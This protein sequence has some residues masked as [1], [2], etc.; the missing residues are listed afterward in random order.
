MQVERAP[1]WQPQHAG[2]SRV[3]LVP[4]V[5]FDEFNTLLK[6]LKEEYYETVDGCVQGA[7][8]NN[9]LMTPRSISHCG[10]LGVWRELTQKGRDSFLKLTKG[11]GYEWCVAINAFLMTAMDSSARTFFFF[12][13]H[14]MMGDV[15]LEEYQE[16]LVTVL[17]REV[18][19]FLS[20]WDLQ[21]TGYYSFMRKNFKCY[22]S[23][24]DSEYIDIPIAMYQQIML[25]FA[26]GTHR[27]LGGND[28]C[29]IG[30]LPSELVVYLFAWESSF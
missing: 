25:A 29:L 27:R 11:Y 14:P 6:Q 12:H 10:L 24:E 28:G 15:S 5:S 19:L 20:D 17:R 26:M 18:K 9:N 30:S 13:L 7:L 23:S 2:Y 1:I 3:P 4:Y 8:K 22:G 16:E 21:P